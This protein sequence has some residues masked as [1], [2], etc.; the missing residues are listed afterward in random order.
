YTLPI[1]FPSIS[2]HLHHFT[3]KPIKVAVCTSCKK[4]KTRKFPP[5][6]LN[7]LQEIIQVPI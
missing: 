2:L 7:I 6:L 5:I 3:N 1:A 4:P